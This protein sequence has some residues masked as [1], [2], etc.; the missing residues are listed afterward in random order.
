[1]DRCEFCPIRTLRAMKQNAQDTSKVCLGGFVK[2][3]GPTSHAS[4]MCQE[5]LS[6]L[7]IEPI[8]TT[9]IPRAIIASVCSVERSVEVWY[10]AS[11]EDVASVFM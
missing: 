6:M 7:T 8:Q 5:S 2:C 10:T 9:A 3:S 1:M 11:N 4:R